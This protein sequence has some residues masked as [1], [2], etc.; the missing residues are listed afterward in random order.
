MVELELSQA[1]A[2]PPA[3]LHAGSAPDVA[4]TIGL[5]VSTVSPLTGY[6]ARKVCLIRL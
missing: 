1:S 4:L 3:F 2:A 5:R 6:T